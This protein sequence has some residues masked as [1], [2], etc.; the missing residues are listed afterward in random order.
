MGHRIGKFVV[1]H[2]NSVQLTHDGQPDIVIASFQ[3]CDYTRYGNAVA[4]FKTQLVKV[5]F[6]LFSRFEL[7][8]SQLRF[9]E[10]RLI[11]V[12]KL[13]G[14]LVYNGAGGLFH[15]IYGQT[16]HILSYISVVTIIPPL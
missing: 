2:D 4:V 13:L 12:Q 14:M 10:N 3:R 8:V 16:E 15:F 11:E 9:L 7:L 1:G 6:Y 5:G